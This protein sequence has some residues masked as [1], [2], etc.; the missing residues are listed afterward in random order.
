MATRWKWSVAIT[1][2]VLPVIL[3]G[4]RK[5]DSTVH[6]TG[7]V[8]YDGRPVPCGNIWFIPDHK[9]GNSGHGSMALIRDGKY[10]TQSGLGV[11]GGAHLVRIEAFDG[12][13]HGDN[14]DGKLITKP[15]EQ[16]FELPMTSGT[17]DF[18]I[19]AGPQ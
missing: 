13:V 3:A 11:V 14:A 5:D 6:L 2:F 19:P 15:Y 8:T 12:V 4:C 7:S 10:D 9:Q 1:A 17:L 16:S 18:E